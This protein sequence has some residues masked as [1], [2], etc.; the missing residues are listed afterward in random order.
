V[1]PFALATSVI[2]GTWT[3]GTSIGRCDPPPAAI[4]SGIV[5]PLLVGMNPS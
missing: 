2:V 3:I 4:C 1:T 5:A